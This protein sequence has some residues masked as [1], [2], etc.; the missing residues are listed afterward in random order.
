MSSFKD[1]VEDIVGV[2]V[3]D[4]TA[5]NDYL[6][7]SAREISDVLPDEVLLYNA[8]LWETATT[9]DIS[10]NRIF[11]VSR[12]GRG[13]VEIP[14][15]M[16]TQA[17]DSE[18][19]HYATV[20]SP[21]HY[22]EGSTLTILPA[23][24]SSE[25][26]QILRFKY[27][28]VV[29]TATGIDS[30]PDNAE[31]AVTIGSSCSVIM[32]LMSVTREAIPSSLSI[33]DLSVVASLGGAPNIATVSYSDATN[34]NASAESVGT[35]TTVAPLI[36]NVS[37]SAPTYLKP[38][39]TFDITQLETFL[40]DQEDS[41]LAQI[42]IGRIQHELGEY[43][44]DI[45]NEL[46]EFNK[47]NARYQMEFQEAVTK[48]NQDLQV[49]ITNANMK[50]QRLQQE[51]QMTTD[52]DKFN[53]AQDQALIMTNKAKDMESILADNNSKLQKYSSEIQAY[54]A[55]VGDE[56]QEYQANLSQEIQ[57]F[58][59]NLQRTQAILQALGAQYQQCQAKF[60]GE[61]QRLSGAKV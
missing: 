60:Q 44:A 38:S 55:K 17:K 23:P 18:S 42:Q 39:G 31:Y 54:Q 21:M 46:N 56:V 40:E 15:G 33:S 52:I 7:A 41:E 9:V 32:N 57:E 27:P 53:K 45:Q 49:A 2:A 22:F 3:S 25:K 14:F 24:T 12:N 6:T 30:F 5:L 37:G 61:L 13:T 11:S 59:A 16:S 58:G 36:I 26:G 19:I 34:S 1:K 20:R 8:T 4:T 35:S 51:A 47:E 29:Y 48:S 10:N 28:T 50:A 43:Q